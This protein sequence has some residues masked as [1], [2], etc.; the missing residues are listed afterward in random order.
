[1]EAKL[2]VSSASYGLHVLSLSA[3]LCSRAEIGS[4]FGRNLMRC[5]TFNKISWYLGFQGVYNAFMTKTLRSGLFFIYHVNDMLSYIESND[6]W[7][8]HWTVTFLFLL[9]R[10]NVPNMWRR[11][12]YLPPLPTFFSA[13]L[14]PSI[15]LFPALPV[16]LLA[17]CCSAPFSA[18]EKAWQMWQIW[19][20]VEIAPTRQ[21]FSTWS[22]PDPVALS[23][24]QIGLP[25][26]I[27]PLLLPQSFSKRRETRH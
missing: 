17:S 3:S 15:V 26:F 7:N 9:R 2:D 10:I 14:T 20:Y 11:Q 27:P 19:S 23:E 18:A 21:R 22:I 16:S 8:P 13:F 5:Y 6:K 24:P 4:L 1:M 12:L 25:P